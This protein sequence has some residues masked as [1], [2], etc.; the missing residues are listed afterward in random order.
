MIID[1]AV[2]NVGMLLEIE[3][4]VYIHMTLMFK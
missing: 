4:I 1:V 3:G 2:D